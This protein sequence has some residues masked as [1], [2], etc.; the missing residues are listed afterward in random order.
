MSSDDA[1]SGPG[2]SSG[3]AG[4]WKKRNNEIVEILPNG[5]GAMS[6]FVPTSAKDTPRT[7]EMLCRNYRAACDEERVPPLLIVATFVFDL[8]CIH[9]F[10]DE[11]GRVSR[12]AT[13]L[14]LPIAR[15]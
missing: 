14:L 8:L 9:P 5:R 4:E 15:F 13:S 10:R 6:R 3:D 7:V 12:L 1:R 2:G 11:N